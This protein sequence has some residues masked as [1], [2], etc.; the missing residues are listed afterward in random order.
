MYFI[1]NL[2]RGSINSDV[3]K[4]SL[5]LL[6]LSK[7]SDISTDL[8]VSPGLAFTSTVKKTLRRC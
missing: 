2:P 6:K 4:E 8:L 3:D 1:D 7:L 5:V